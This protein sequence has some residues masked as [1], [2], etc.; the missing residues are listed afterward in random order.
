MNPYPQKNV[1]LSELKDDIYNMHREIMQ[2]SELIMREVESLIFAGEIEYAELRLKNNIK[3]ALL[4]A[5]FFNQ[6][7]HQQLEEFEFLNAP[8]AVAAYLYDWVTLYDNLQSQYQK[9]NLIML[10]KIRE[11]QKLR[12]EKTSP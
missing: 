9:V 8:E 11:S 5:E 12:D 6:N 3:K 7:I 4:D 10:E 1:S 2:S